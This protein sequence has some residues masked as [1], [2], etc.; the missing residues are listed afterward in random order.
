MDGVGLL[1]EE[2]ESLVGTQSE[3]ETDVHPARA[4]GKRCEDCGPQ[5]GPPTCRGFVI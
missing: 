2:P 3:M 5:G 4:V 1:G